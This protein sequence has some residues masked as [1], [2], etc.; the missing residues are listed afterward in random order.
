MSILSALSS[1]PLPYGVACATLACALW[2]FPF[3]APKLLNN[4]HPLLLTTG[5]YGV[6][7][8]MALL[9]AV[10]RWTSTSALIFGPHG[11]VALGLSVMSNTV[12]YTLL[13]AA[14]QWTSPAVVGVIIG[15]LPVWVSM[16]GRERDAPIAPLLLPLGLIASG[17]ALINWQALHNLPA[18]LNTTF[19]AGVVCACAATA[20]WTAYSVLNSRY[21]KL[22][23][24]IGQFDWTNVLA[25]SA[26]APLV[27]ALPLLW[28]WQPSAF[29]LG[30]RWV[31]FLWMSA[32]LGIGASWA[33]TY[34]WNA[35]S[36]ALPTTLTGQLIVIETVFV[37]IFGFA[38]D[39]RWPNTQ[40]WLAMAFCISG[41]VM[42]VRQANGSSR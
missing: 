5:R 15:T 6:Y 23:R 16:I 25:F 13:S 22:H 10:P 33:A 26:A 37:L 2:G 14:V 41:V 31:T 21:L 32:L 35:A 29:A 11:K 7:A 24:D 8:L 42:A 12:Y 17:I 18:H 30:N 27:I 9:L 20:C 19:F 36:R 40:E 28:W 4:I 3:L 38:Y 34:L 1:R 39:A